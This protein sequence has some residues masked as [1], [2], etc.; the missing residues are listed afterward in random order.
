MATSTNIPATEPRIHS[1]LAEAHA[2]LQELEVTR[3]TLL[4]RG[5]SADDLPAAH[6]LRAFAALLDHD[7]A[8]VLAQVAEDPWTQLL[9]RGLVN[10]T[11]PESVG[12]AQLRLL[13]HILPLLATV[14][15]LETTLS[16]EDIDLPEPPSGLLRVLGTT[17]GC[18]WGEPLRVQI[19]ASRGVLAL[20][21]HADAALDLEPILRRAGGS[22]L[23]QEEVHLLA[24]EGR[25]ILTVQTTAGA[26]YRSVVPVRLA[27]SVEEMW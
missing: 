9:D 3:L 26:I 21:V 10:V 13:A 16:A 20:R 5:L 23:I 4:Q 25:L 24:D 6:H 19:V 27:Q 22:G 12:T 18:Y 17:S 11:E 2:A 15:T 1:L 14:D 8:S 7:R